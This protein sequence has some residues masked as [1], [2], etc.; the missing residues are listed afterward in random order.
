MAYVLRP[1]DSRLGVG[2]KKRQVVEPGESR[3]SVAVTVAWTLSVTT[4]LLCEA[5][6]VLAYLSARLDPPAERIQ[7]LGQWLLLASALIGCIS[8]ALLP[9]V[10]RMRRV[11]PPLG[12]TVFAICA[13]A[14]PIV[15][16]I[17]QLLR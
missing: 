9:A 5:A 1:R 11:L 15:A 2:K 12:F 13:A 7:L 3:A 4:V 14:A 16:V 6:A 17:A 10:Y 8:L